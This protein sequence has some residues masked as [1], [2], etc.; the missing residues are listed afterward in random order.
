MESREMVCINCPLGCM[1]TVTKE[2]DGSV[3]VSGNTCPR[4]EEY[5]RTELTN[6]KR[7]VTST[8]RVKGEKRGVVS[9]KTAAPVPKEKMMDCIEE[10]KEAEV[11][12]PVSVGDVIIENVANTGVAIIATRDF[13]E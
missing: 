9:V 3:T 1:L 13:K 12:A 7:I 8:V 5:G 4:G 10:L 11:C 6:P 2:N